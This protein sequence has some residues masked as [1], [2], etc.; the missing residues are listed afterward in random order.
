MINTIQFLPNAARLLQDFSDRLYSE[1]DNIRL[2]QTQGKEYNQQSVALFGA[3]NEGV[4]RHRFRVSPAAISMLQK[5]VPKLNPEEFKKV[6]VIVTGATPN[7]ISRFKLSDLKKDTVPDPIKPDDKSDPKDNSNSDSVASK[8][9]GFFGWF[10]ILLLLG[11]VVFA[12]WYLV[13]REQLKTK[14]RENMIEDTPE[15]EI[16][17]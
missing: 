8:G 16:Y 6:E 3:Y 4:K 9:I 11:G 12:A 17:A 10:L 15:M 13:R 7:Q 14:A 2:L 1:S 5:D